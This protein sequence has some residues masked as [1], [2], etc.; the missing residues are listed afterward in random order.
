LSDLV[1]EGPNDRSQAIYCLEQ[2]QSKIRP[3]DTV[4]E[5]KGFWE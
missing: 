1:P 3:V 2:V 5:V 4:L